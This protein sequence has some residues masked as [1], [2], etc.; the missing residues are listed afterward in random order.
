MFVTHKLILH[1][2]LGFLASVEIDLRHASQSSPI[3]LHYS[4]ISLS[5]K[6]QKLENK[7]IENEIIKNK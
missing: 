7:K 1:L 2:Q 3:P 5:I 4:E 6:R